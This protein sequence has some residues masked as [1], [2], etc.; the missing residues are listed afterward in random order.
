MS[1][2]ISQLIN[3]PGPI[4]RPYNPHN[5]ETILE[6]G[7]QM[8]YQNENTRSWFQ[9]C[10]N[11]LVLQVGDSCNT[12]GELQYLSWLYLT[13][14]QKVNLRSLKTSSNGKFEYYCKQCSQN[15]GIKNSIFAG[16]PDSAHEEEVCKFFL[17]SFYC[18]Y[19]THYYKYNYRNGILLVFNTLLLTV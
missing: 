7:T 10:L 18:N 16:K 14:K 13:A 15:T 19:L 12:R 17:F 1:I 11:H 2:K 3:D 4:P 6:Y 9:R 5:L 8:R